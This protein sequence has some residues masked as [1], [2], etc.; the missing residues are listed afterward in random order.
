MDFL[1]RLNDED[2]RIKIRRVH[3][4]FMNEMNEHGERNDKNTN[5]A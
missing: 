1:I 4:T 2:V 3:L 5:C